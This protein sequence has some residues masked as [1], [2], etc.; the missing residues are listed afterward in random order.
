MPKIA[1]VMDPIDSLALKKDST[2]AMIRAAQV[3]D[4]E[5]YYLEQRDLF[6]MGGEAAGEFRKLKLT[7]GFAANLD[8]NQIGSEGWYTLGVSRLLIIE[9]DI[10]AASK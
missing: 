1:F 9:R 4:L 6:L 2:L 7:A 5:V 10:S 8:T 3:R